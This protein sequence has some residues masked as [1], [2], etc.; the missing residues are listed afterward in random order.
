MLPGTL[1]RAGWASP[2]FLKQRWAADHPAPRPSTVGTQRGSRQPRKHCHLERF[3]TCLRVLPLCPLVL[4]IQ[5]QRPEAVT[6]GGRG[7]CWPCQSLRALTALEGKPRLTS[8]GALKI[9]KRFPCRGA[10]GRRASDRTAG[11]GR[12]GTPR[13]APASP[14]RHQV[15]AIPRAPGERVPLPRGQSSPLPQCHHIRPSADRDRVRDTDKT[16]RHSPT[17]SGCHS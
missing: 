9:H 6:G 11:S 15:S 1:S 3:R 5:T 4:A 16:D 13:Q 7:H 10:W 2:S 12:A 8:P 14:Q 17:A